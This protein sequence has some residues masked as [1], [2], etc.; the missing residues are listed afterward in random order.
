MVINEV[1]RTDMIPDIQMESR[2]NDLLFLLP[3]I[4]QLGK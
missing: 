4:Q 2:V 3:F 1:T